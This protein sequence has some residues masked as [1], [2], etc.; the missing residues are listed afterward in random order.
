MRSLIIAAVFFA[1]LNIASGQSADATYEFDCHKFKDICKND[2]TCS[3]NKNCVCSDLNDGYDC[4]NV[5]AEST[6][7][8]SDDPA[9]V[10]PCLNG[11]T[12]YKTGSDPPARCVCPY[13][14]YEDNC[15]KKL[16]EIACQGETASYALTFPPEF[17]G[18]VIL[19]NAS[20]DSSNA[21][22]EFKETK[23]V[24]K[25][26]YS[27]TV[28]IT[29]DD[30]K[31]DPCKKSNLQI[32]DTSRTFQAMI[33]VYYTEH[34]ETNIDEIFRMNCTHNTENGEVS[35]DVKN[36]NVDKDTLDKNEEEQQYGPFELAIT[37]D[38]S[39][40]IDSSKPID[41]GDN[42][43][44]DLY[45]RAN[46]GYTKV[47]FHTCIANNTLEGPDNRTL[48]FLYKGCSTLDGIV[49]SA[50][51]VSI[52]KAEAEVTKNGVSV[53]FNVF[54]FSSSDKIGVICLARACKVGDTSCDLPTNCAEIMKENPAVDEGVNGD[55]GNGNENN[56]ENGQSRKKRA[57][58]NEEN[59]V[60]ITK[61]FTVGGSK[62]DKKN[63][64]TENEAE[65]Y[66]DPVEECL[67]RIEITAVVAVL[68]AV[69]CVLLIVCTVLACVI[70]RRRGKHISTYD[71]PVLQPTPDRFQIPRAHV[72]ES[73]EIM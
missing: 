56:N 44:L 41:V 65:E 40:P 5:K 61:V 46:S 72:N 14:Y 7:L 66:V 29:D 19:V 43:S 2:G 71:R 53:S 70:L 59:E 8:C 39:T 15:E 25:T 21:A 73:Y 32:F 22:C 57:A 69:V 18:R 11:G 48:Q 35:I 24:T 68:S 54:K 37:D 31:Q 27:L 9:V 42:V 33:L 17:N 58:E 13:G 45:P 62:Q 3:E 6:I 36:V 20:Y 49:V 60:S 28:D 63:T 4:S 16:A 55:N 50:N 52:S 26:T 34:L 12:C 30:S 47:F 51:Q 64:T 67:A 38:E 1:I 23:D 10:D